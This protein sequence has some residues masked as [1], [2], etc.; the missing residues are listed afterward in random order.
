MNISAHLADWYL[1]RLQFEP[2]PDAPGLYRLTHPDQGGLRRTRQA[3][4]DLR[5]QGYTVQ[6][7]IRL[8][9]SF[10]ASPIHPFRPDGLQERRSRL[11]KAA[12]G[13]TT[14]RSAQPTTSPPAVRPIPPK[15]AYAPTAHV[16]AATGGRSR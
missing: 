9:P 4:R 6:A 3:V 1:V 2:V 11:A 13:R 16:T 10:P 14:Q 8:D 7:D 12:T 5:G 15:P